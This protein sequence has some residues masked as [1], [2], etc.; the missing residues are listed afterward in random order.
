MLL[1]VF[2][3]Y[4]FIVVYCWLQNYIEYN[5]IARKFVRKIRL[6]VRKMGLK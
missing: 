4:I 2:S 5:R 3:F 1:K 6:F